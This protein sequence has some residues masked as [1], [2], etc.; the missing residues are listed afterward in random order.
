MSAK[1]LNFQ[2]RLTEGLRALCLWGALQVDLEH[3]RV[4]KGLRL[5]DGRQ[6]GAAESV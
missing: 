5:Q 3:A 6:N 2:L 1:F 4:C